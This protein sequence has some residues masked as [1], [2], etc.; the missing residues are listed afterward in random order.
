MI[1]AHP[2]ETRPGKES[3]ETVSDWVRKNQMTYLPNVIYVPPEEYLSSY[4]LIRASKFIMV[5]NSTIGLEA[6]VMGAA[7]LCG[8]RSRYT[9]VPLCYFPKTIPEYLE[10]AE[11]LLKCDAVSVPVGL[12]R[13]E[14]VCIGFHHFQD[15]LP[16]LFFRHIFKHGL[17]P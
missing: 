17:P 4:E 9:Q 11:E 15:L 6:A 14:A 12:F 16:G 5:Y 8:G 1:R 10:K 3:H 13:V 2:D 7:V